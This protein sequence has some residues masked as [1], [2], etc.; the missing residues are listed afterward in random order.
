MN[1]TDD[2]ENCL[3]VLRAGGVILYPTDTIWGLGC[4]ATDEE[5][6]QKIYHIKQR[7]ETK[8]MIVLLA[9]ERDIFQYVAQPDP[10]VFD[11]LENT[12]KP[13]TV[14]YKGAIGMAD[15]L[16]AEDGSIAIRLVRDEFCRHIIKRLRKPLVSTSANISGQPT[17]ASFT[18]IDPR[19][20]NASDYVVEYRRND[21]QPAQPSSI[22]KWNEDGSVTVIRG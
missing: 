6:V 11:Y 14:I 2:I 20:I 22:I 17:P 12:A 18:S 7:Q 15:N 1:F 8:S 9:D 5:A 21:E 3:R 13:T 16:I 4:D 10:A 19:I